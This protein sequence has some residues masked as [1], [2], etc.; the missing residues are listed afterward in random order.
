[1]NTP[2]DPFEEELRALRPVAP[3]HELASSIGAALADPPV[4]VAR[5][6][7][8]S[9]LIPISLWLSW[10]AAAAMAIALLWPEARPPTPDTANTPPTSPAATGDAPRFTPVSSS[11]TLVGTRDEGVVYL[12]DGTPARKVRYEYLDTVNLMSTDDTRAVLNVSRP[13]EEIRLVPVQTL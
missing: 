10:G 11:M 1:M 4:P 2:I 13:R 12:D 8:R 9:R 7:A 3:G 6:G 5:A